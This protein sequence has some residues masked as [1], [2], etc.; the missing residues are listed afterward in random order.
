MYNFTKPQNNYPRW[1][2]YF[3]A[4]PALPLTES[5]TPF[6]FNWAANA[7]NTMDDL[8][9]NLEHMAHDVSIS[10]PANLGWSLDGAILI[11][12]DLYKIIDSQESVVQSSAHSLLR[13]ERTQ[14]TIRLKKISNPIKLR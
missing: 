2:R 5:G 3:S 13:E 6:R 14:Y 7:M 9:S 1:G 10:T 8:V 4:V 11:D 12:G